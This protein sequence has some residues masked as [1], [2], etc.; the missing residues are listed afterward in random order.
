MGAPALK[1]RFVLVATVVTGCTCC[2]GTRAAEDAA[3]SRSAPLGGEII[4]AGQFAATGPRY[5]PDGTRIAFTARRGSKNDIAIVPSAGGPPTFVTKG[6]SNIHPAWSPDA[7][8]LV[9]VSHSGGEADLYVIPAAGGAAVRITHSGAAKAAPDWSPD[10]RT[11]AY[12]SSE[13]GDWNIWSVP[14]SG[15][16][17]RK[18]TR[19]RGDEWNPRY[20]PDGR[21]ILFSTNWGENANIDTWAIPGGGGE[22]VRLTFG[23]EDEVTAAWSPDSRRIAFLTDLGGL[24]VMDLASGSRTNV[25]PGEGFQDILSWSLD[26]RW[27]AVGRNPKP[28]R[29]F[30]VSLDGGEPRPLGLAEWNVWTPDVSRISGAIAFAAMDR[31]GNGDVQLLRGPGSRLVRFTANPAPD[32]HPAW[33]PSGKQIAFTS[34]RDGAHNGDIWVAPTTKG[35]PAVR[36]TWLRSAHRPRWCSDNVIVFHSD[37]GADGQPHVW[38]V[39]RGKAPRQLTYGR[40]EVEP[41]CVPATGDVL[42]VGSSSR[43]SELFRTTLVGGQATQLTHDGASARFPRVSRN[44][45]WIAFVSTREGPSEI[46]IMPSGGG[47]ARRLTSDGGEKSPPAWSSDGK[48]LVYSVKRGEP[49]IRRYAA[50]ACSLHSC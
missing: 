50:P 7:T 40:R 25:A 20:S 44:G 33:S 24:F 26:G 5:S 36:L 22:P 17:A 9:Y 1:S 8:R 12:S 18:L 10:G 46:F 38:A 32:L 41:D 30:Q 3:A 2:V 48:S 29:L 6:G 16:P 49:Q 28:Y 27:I 14:A 23:P 43:G 37:R 39:E 15:G 31:S 47:P 21:S 11:I 42:Y 4:V 34:R 19:H 13:G 45:A 35:G